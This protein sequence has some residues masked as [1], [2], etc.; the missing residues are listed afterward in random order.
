M[1]FEHLSFQAQ[2]GPPRSPPPSLQTN[3]WRVC[4]VAALR[5]ALH[6]GARLKRMREHDPA[7]FLYPADAQLTTVGPES[8]QAES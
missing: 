4:A 5:P 3:D 8:S 1:P 6:A 7:P 2:P